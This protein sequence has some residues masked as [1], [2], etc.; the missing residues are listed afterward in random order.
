[1]FWFIILPILAALGVFVWS[2][3]SLKVDGESHPVLSGIVAGFFPALFMG[4][5]SLALGMAVAL[6]V[7]NITADEDKMVLTD[8]TPI[9][10]L[11]DGSSVGGNFFLGTGS[12]KSESYYVYYE[13]AGDGYRQR[14]TNVDKTLI[15]EDATVETARIETYNDKSETTFW[16]LRKRNP[17]YIIHVPEGTIIRNFI[18]DSN[19]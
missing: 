10:S 1:M 12:I 6:I 11:A 14:K 18:L 3:W 9:V 16:A 4:M 5:F 15:M 8:A 13:K 17:T 19:S 7:G 2:A